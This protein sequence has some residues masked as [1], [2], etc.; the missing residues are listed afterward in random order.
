[1]R[2]CRTEEVI[3]TYG[4]LAAMLDFWH[5]STSRE[6]GNATTRKLDPENMV[7]AVEILMLCVI[8]SEILLLPVSWLPS[9]IF[10][11]G[12]VGHDCWTFRCFIR[13]HKPLYCF[14]NDMCICKT[15]KVIRTSG[16]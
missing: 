9:W 16:N 6:I 12:S 8:V 10:D 5:T 15:S 11:T 4:T 1:M 14:W 13:S 2:I 7:L 3:T